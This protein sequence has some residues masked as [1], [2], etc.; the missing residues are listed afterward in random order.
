M[1]EK[2]DKAKNFWKSTNLIK[3]DKVQKYKVILHNLI[4][5]VPS[6]GLKTIHHHT[7]VNKKMDKLRLDPG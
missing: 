6:K 3:K 7:I 4:K 2:I 5:T 1:F